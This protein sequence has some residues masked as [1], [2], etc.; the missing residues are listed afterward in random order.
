MGSVFHDSERLRRQV[1]S[2]TPL[3]RFGGASELAG[4]V[5]FLAGESSGYVTGQ[6]LAVDGGYGLG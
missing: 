3:A 2:R 1:S 6:V 5:Q 4:V